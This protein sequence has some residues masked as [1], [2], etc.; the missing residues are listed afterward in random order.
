MH[1]WHY[2]FPTN[3]TYF[4]HIFKSFKSLYDEN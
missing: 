1:E 4:N 2:V 3:F